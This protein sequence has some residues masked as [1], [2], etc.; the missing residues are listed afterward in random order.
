MVEWSRGKFTYGSNKTTDQECIWYSPACLPRERMDLFDAG[1]SGT[2]RFR[3][4]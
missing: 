1:F 4:D 3:L 2:A